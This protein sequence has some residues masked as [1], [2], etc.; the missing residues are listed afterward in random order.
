F[1][2]GIGSLLDGRQPW[3]VQ[4]AVVISLLNVLLAPPDKRLRRFWSPISHLPDLCVCS[5][6]SGREQGNARRYKQSR[7]P[8]AVIEPLVKEKI[9][10]RKNC[11][12]KLRTQKPVPPG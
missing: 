2:Q 7:R 3:R 8:T 6:N 10:H 1:W 4:C 11:P 9:W 5:D 12:Q